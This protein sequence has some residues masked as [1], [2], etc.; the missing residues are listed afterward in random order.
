MEKAKEKDIEEIDN[1][2]SLFD[3]SR[4]E[5]TIIKQGEYYWIRETDFEG[6]EDCGKEVERKGWRNITRVITQARKGYVKIEDAQKEILSYFDI[7]KEDKVTVY[8][9]L[10]CIELMQKQGGKNGNSLY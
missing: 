5:G 9:V 10:K 1:E 6:C 4:E 3:I 8:A 2:K 7:K